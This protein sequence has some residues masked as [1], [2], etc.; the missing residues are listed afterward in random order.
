M[1]MTMNKEIEKKCAEI[2]IKAFID[3]N[4]ALGKQTFS[5][6]KWINNNTIRV[7]DKDGKTA[8]IRYD[9]DTDTVQLI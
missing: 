9:I 8:K 1:K 6:M 2:A 4:F 7:K 5:E 3:S